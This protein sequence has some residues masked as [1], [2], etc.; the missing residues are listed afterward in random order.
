MKE[1][2]N[3]DIK[4]LVRLRGN[5]EPKP[6]SKADPKAEDPSS[7]KSGQKGPKQQSTAPNKSVDNKQTKP[8]SG[9]NPTLQA[10]ISN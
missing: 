5:A 8:K 2:D 6:E 3:Q 1:N 10:P 7:M 4:L 9:K